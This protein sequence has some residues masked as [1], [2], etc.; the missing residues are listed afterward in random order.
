M[1]AFANAKE[2]V[3]KRDFNSGVGTVYDGKII[4]IVDELKIGFVFVKE[5]KLPVPVDLNVAM[6]RNHQTKIFVEGDSVKLT[7]DDSKGMGSIHSDD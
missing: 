6:G 1:H 3:S 4:Q 5:L 7:V 2:A